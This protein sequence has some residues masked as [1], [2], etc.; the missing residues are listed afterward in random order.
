[1]RIHSKLIRVAL[2]IFVC[3]TLTACPMHQRDGHRHSPEKFTLGPAQSLTGFLFCDKASRAV[4]CWEEGGFEIW[5]TD[6]GQRL[7]DRRNL[8]RPVD[9]CLSSSDQ[10]VIVTADRL[11]PNRSQDG[12]SA[13][14]ALPT[15]RIWDAKSGTLKHAIGIREAIGDRFELQF[16]SAQWVGEKQLALV[17]LSR[18]GVGRTACGMKIFVIDVESG[19]LTKI[20]RDYGMIGDRLIQSPDHRLA[21][22]MAD[23][24]LRRDEKLSSV[25][26][27]TRNVLGGIR[28]IDLDS[29]KV[30]S[31][32]HEPRDP[33]AGKGAFF[34]ATIAVWCPDSK[35]V[36]T[37][38][39]NWRDGDHPAPRIHLWDA[40]TGKLRQTFAGHTDYV[41]DIATT[42]DCK[43]LLSAGEDRT[44]RVW[45]VQTGK[46]KYALDSHGAGV[47]K[48]VV[49]PGDRLAVSAA[50]EKA[51]RVW[52]LV[53]GKLKFDLGGH[54]SAVRSISVLSST[55]IS[56]TTLLGTT[57]V[58]D[59]STG[60]R[61]TVTRK[62]PRFPLRMGALEIFENNCQIVLRK[63]KSFEQR[64]Q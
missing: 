26:G 52:D 35:A 39:N 49:L 38:D 6:I 18:E 11:L 60:K 59:C 14:D 17:W 23:N 47:N 22:A 61:L 48:V 4:F 27:I 50:E 1:M 54:D 10:T 19:K 40:S 63:V 51:A 5:D 53:G 42:S 58:W 28:V 2:V 32:W 36:I 57:T 55:K 33:K 30:I 25:T 15:I 8:P 41:L 64:P 29:L 46:L 21:I 43:C 7:G 56:T 37:V 16:W 12:R 3:I 45:D 13:K 31:S 34:Y 20:S 44:I 24:N 9:W 62:A